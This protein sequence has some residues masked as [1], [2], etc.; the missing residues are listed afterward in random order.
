M[1]LEHTLDRID[2]D[3]VESDIWKV[4]RDIK[5]T[6][7][8]IIM[9]VWILEILDKLDELLIEVLLAFVKEA[10]TNTEDNSSFGGSDRLGLS[11][12]QQQ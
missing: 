9:L 8:E 6:Q 10:L 3:L 12:Y 2:V 4:G 5:D 7:S 11:W 1:N